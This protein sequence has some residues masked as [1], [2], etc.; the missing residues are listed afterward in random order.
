MQG[1]VS[2]GKSILNARAEFVR[3]RGFDAR[4]PG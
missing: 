1:R 3:E 2:N 4:E